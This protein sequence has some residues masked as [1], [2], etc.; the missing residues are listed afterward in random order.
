MTYYE[1]L[2]EDAMTG[3]RDAINELESRA[4]AGDNE[5]QYY[6]A[7]YY[8]TRKKCDTSLFDYWIEKAAKNGNN[9]ARKYLGLPEVKRQETDF[10]MNPKVFLFGMRTLI[11]LMG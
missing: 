4:G 8:A 3:N 11:E 5:A 10:G 1:K 2:Q 9:N 6:L 7:Y